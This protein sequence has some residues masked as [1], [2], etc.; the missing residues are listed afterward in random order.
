MPPRLDQERIA[1]FL[2]V[3]TVRIDA[4]IAEK[5]TLRT[6]VQEL[7]QLVLVQQLSKDW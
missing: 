1:N 7:L 2:D 4:L 6:A 3:Q 5:E